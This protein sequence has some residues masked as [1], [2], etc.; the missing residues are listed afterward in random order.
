MS[1]T[2]IH[3]RVLDGQM[4]NQTS[5]PR[6]YP[7]RV[8]RRKVL[9]SYNRGVEGA[10]ASGSTAAFRSSAGPL[11]SSGSARSAIGRLFVALPIAYHFEVR[12]LSQADRNTLNSRE[13]GP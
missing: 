6:S 3:A 2:R 1:Q 5:I 7:D 11:G 8:G 13:I 4:D 12:T 10:C 9:R